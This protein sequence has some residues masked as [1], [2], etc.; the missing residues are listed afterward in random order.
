MKKHLLLSLILCMG[1]SIHAQNAEKIIQVTINNDWKESI[2]R[3][4]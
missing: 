2:L 1:I 4:Q 3:M